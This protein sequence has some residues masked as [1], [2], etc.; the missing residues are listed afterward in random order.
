MVQRYLCARSQR[1]AGR[2]LLLSGFVVFGQFALFLFIGIGLACYDYQYPT[3][4]LRDHHDEVFA[5]FIVNHLPVGIAGLTLAAVFAAAMSTLSSSLNSSAT[6]TVNDLYLSVAKKPPSPERLVTISRLLTIV[7]G[8]IQ[9]GVGIRAQHFA[10]HVVNNVL[11]IAGFATGILLG[12][13]LLGVLTQ[14]VGQAAALIG[15]LV[16]ITTV[17]TVKFQTELAWPWYAAVGAS[18]TFV[19]GL[20][21]SVL[22]TRTPS[23]IS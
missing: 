9:I 17:T 2:A 1:D 5:A 22:W 14:R 11:A 16:G 19:T 13:F 21:V 20:T 3:D 18:A 12:V 6:S 8:L 15:M 7:F 10:S 4:I 23:E